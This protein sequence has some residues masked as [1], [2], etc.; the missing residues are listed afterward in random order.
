VN[1]AAALALAAALLVAVAP[2]VPALGGPTLL[3]VSGSTTLVDLAISPF[4][5]EG[6][7]PPPAL[8][9]FLL[10]TVCAGLGLTGRARLSWIPALLLVATAGWTWSVLRAEWALSVQFL[11]GGKEAHPFYTYVEPWPWL[12]LGPAVML[13]GIASWRSVR[14]LRRA[15]A[16]AVHKVFE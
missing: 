13:L 12:F 16:A 5:R 3:G 1:A 8:L 10:A 2:L 15:G 9:L 14:E 11:P 6:S 7:G 4:Q